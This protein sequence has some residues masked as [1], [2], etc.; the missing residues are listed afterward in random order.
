MFRRFGSQ[1]WQVA[2]LMGLM[3][4]L[5]GCGGGGGVSGPSGTLTGTVQ[6]LPGRQALT[7]VASGTVQ[8]Y[9]D[10]NRVASGVIASG[11]YRVT[12]P[13]PP[14]V[15]QATVVVTANFVAGSIAQRRKH[16]T[17][18]VVRVNAT[19]QADINPTTTLATAAL[20]Q[21]PNTVPPDLDINAFV[22]AQQNLQIDLTQVD[23]SSD[24]KIQQA[25]PVMLVVT[26]NPS[27]A[28]VLI[29]EQPQQQASTP[30]FLRSGLQGG[31]N[32]TVQVRRQAT[33]GNET[34][35]TTLG[36]SVTLKVRGSTPVHFDFTPQIVSAQVA[37]G[38]LNL[39]VKNA[40]SANE[41][42]IVRFGDTQAV[43]AT[44]ASV[45]EQGVATISVTIPQGVSGQVQVRVQN[46]ARTSAAQNVSI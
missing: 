24:D 35:T 28:Q 14:D 2:S 30:F 6:T 29:N 23:F 12:V 10:G 27:G 46:A 8:V 33:I 22:Q 34:I 15:S 3:A 21:A 18:A 20:E 26:S 44:I 38:A 42:V 45:D 11:Q 41:K 13:L 32:L 19:Q 16:K 4:V 25:L 5:V 31:D 17:V 36:K 1:R 7:P 43:V 40:G 37:N 9:L 39:Q